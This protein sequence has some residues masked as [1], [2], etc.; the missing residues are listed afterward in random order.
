LGS[1][2]GLGQGREGGKWDRRKEG[3]GFGVGAWTNF[4]AKKSKFLI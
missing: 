4:L 2:G 3:V 1:F